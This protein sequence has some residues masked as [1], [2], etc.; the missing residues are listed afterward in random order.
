MLLK[1]S[2]ACTKTAL[3]TESAWKVRSGGLGRGDCSIRHETG[4]NDLEGQCKPGNES[5]EI[6]ANTCAHGQKAG[7]KGNHGEEQ[8]NNNEGEHEAS[9]QEVVICAI[10]S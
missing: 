10:R 7:E 5:R 8:A 1:P 4:S 2:R 9:H 6:A 3:D